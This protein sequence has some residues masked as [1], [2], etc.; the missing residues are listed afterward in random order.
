MIAKLT[1]YEIDFLGALFRK[2]AG[3]ILAMTDVYCRINRARG[4]EIDEHGSLSAEQLS[5]LVH[6]PVIL[7]KER[8][9]CAEQR[10]LACRDDTVEGLR[11]YPN[12][13]LEKI[14]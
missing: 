10:G 13:F 7:A 1:G 11:F 2:D 12:L 9:I 8:L 14:E 5:P 3:G 6:I 4:L